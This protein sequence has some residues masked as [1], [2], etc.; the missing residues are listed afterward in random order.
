MKYTL[1][2]TDTK[3]IK[4]FMVCR[5]I[6]ED[7][8]IGGYVEHGDNLSQ[9][10]D[11]WIDSHSVVMNDAVVKGNATVVGKSLVCDNAIIKDDGVVVNSIVGKNAVVSDCAM[12]DGGTLANATIHGDMCIRG[13]CLEQPVLIKHLLPDDLI[14]YNTS[15]QLNTSVF[16]AHELLNDRAYYK[17]IMK[18]HKKYNGLDHILKTLVKTYKL[19]REYGKNG[20]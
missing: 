5:I 20:I 3:M 1:D 8:E 6:G 2:L 18:K 12:V 4:G 10:G 13:K 9:D 19:R 11:C 17:H 14:I 15:F 16:D 7:G